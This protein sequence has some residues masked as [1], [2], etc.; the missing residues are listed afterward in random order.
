[1]IDQNPSSESGRTDRFVPEEIQFMDTGPA[2]WRITFRSTAWR[3]PTDVYETEED[4]VVRVEVAGMQEDDFTIELDGRF[5]SIRG[6]R[7]DTHERR[8][9]HQMEIQFGEFSSD[10]E[11]LSPVIAAEVRADYENGFLHVVLP[12]ARSRI[13]SIQE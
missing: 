2:H 3:P 9:F 8:A 4:I 6:I 1:M 12:K 10:V 11:L 5:L 7:P 13:I